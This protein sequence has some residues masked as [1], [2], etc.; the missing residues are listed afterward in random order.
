MDDVEEDLKIM[1]RRNWHPVAR[2]WKEWR[3]NLLEAKVGDGLEGLNWQTV[4]TDRK[5]MEEDLLEAKV[6]NRL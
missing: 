1:G 2:D 6:H 4:T 5:G 3:R